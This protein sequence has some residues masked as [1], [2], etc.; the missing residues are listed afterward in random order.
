MVYEF[1]LIIVFIG[2][3]LLHDCIQANFKSLILSVFTCTYD[4]SVVPVKN[5]TSSKKNAI[6]LIMHG[7]KNIF[8]ANSLETTM[9]SSSFICETF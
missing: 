3:S 8:S 1:L 4:L 5:S 2:S 7:K 6:L 9:S